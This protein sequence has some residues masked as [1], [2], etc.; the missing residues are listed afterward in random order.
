MLRWCQHKSVHTAGSVSISVRF[1]FECLSLGIEEDNF[2]ETDFPTPNNFTQ[3]VSG[4]KWSFTSGSACVLT[5]D[6]V[7][8]SVAIPLLLEDGNERLAE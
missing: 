2:I 6:R 7:F 3:Q 5:G 1:A 4:A 8:N